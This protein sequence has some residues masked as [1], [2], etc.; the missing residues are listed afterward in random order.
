ML[1]YTGSIK[2]SWDRNKDDEH[3][4]YLSEITLNYSGNFPLNSLELKINLR[5]KSEC[6]EFKRFIDGDSDRAI[7]DG[8]E[9]TIT[10]T[11]D[12]SRREFVFSLSYQGPCVGLSFRLDHSVCHE[13]FK[14]LLSDLEKYPRR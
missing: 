6:Y 5:D 12:S 14:A 11:S 10:I 1:S 7:I 9:G 3:Y 13:A 8:S 4:K 2:D